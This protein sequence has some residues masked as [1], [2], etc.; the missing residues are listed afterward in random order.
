MNGVYKTICIDAGHGGTD[1]GAVNGAA[2]EKNINLDIALKL[3][4]LFQLDGY[5]VFMVRETDVFSKPIDRAKFA[6]EMKADLYISLHCNSHTQDNAKGTETWYYTGSKEGQALA[7]SIQHSLVKWLGLTDR[8]VKHRK[9]LIVLNATTMPAVLIETA[10]LSN[11]DEK[12]LLLNNG[13]K[14]H[15]ARAIYDGV[16]ALNGEEVYLVDNDI[17]TAVQREY[18]FSDETMDY[19]VK[20]R[21]GKELIERLYEKIKGA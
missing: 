2:Y 19:L 13:F 11:P 8:G 3:K 9:D 12:L 18:N 5:R 20:Y 6:N 16:R 21:F 4:T 17:K 10:F 7:E 14:S 1:P 15:V